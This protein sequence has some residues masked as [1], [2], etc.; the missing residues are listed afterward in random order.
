MRT[1][2]GERVLKAIDE[3]NE[4]NIHGLLELASASK[5]VIEGC[6]R[7]RK[8]LDVLVLISPRTSDTAATSHL[9]FWLHQLHHDIYW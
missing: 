8:E 2:V 7:K 5:N 4:V 1:Q 3:T 9:F 6:D